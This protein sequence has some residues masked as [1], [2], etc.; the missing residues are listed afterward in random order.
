MRQLLACTIAFTLALL[1][2]PPAGAQTSAAPAAGP[3]AADGDGPD[4]VP[5]LWT[6]GL[7]AVAAHH[8]VYPGAARRS[9]NA[10]LLPFVTY[11]GP[12]VRLEGGSAG[13]RALRT[14]RTELDFSAAASFGSDGL[15]TG[16]RAG[17]PAIGTLAEIGPSLRINL[18]ELPEDGQRSPWRLDLPLRAVF[19]ADR[20]FDYVGMSFEP[21]LSWRLPPIGD[22]TPSL[23]AG[24]LFGSRALNEMYYG[25]DPVYVTPT[26]PA[27]AAKPGL[28][29][30]RLG[31]SWS[32]PID[33]DL[34]LGLHAS[35]ESVRGGANESSPLVGR[36]VD[37]ILA[38]TLTW[39]AFRSEQPGVK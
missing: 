1:A 27:Y 37:P 32:K 35:I 12:I 22:W 25:V 16:A 28:V 20:D 36:V 4:E 13:L 19:D 11:R 6:A 17:M 23:H 2:S 33:T 31:M 29:A 7:F 24:A 5:A 26:R 30:T 15:D 34:R 14:P 8:A 39:T 10:T 38:I 21:R 9:S 18:G 3:P